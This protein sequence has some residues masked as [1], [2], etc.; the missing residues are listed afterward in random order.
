M[1][2][3]VD[4]S[5]DEWKNNPR[6][7]YYDNLYHIGSALTPGL[8]MKDAANGVRKALYL[9]TP[10]GRQTAMA[11]AQKNAKNLSAG[12]IK[13][14]KGNIDVK[15]HEAFEAAGGAYKTQ[16]L[17]TGLALADSN[18][19][20]WA[21][22]PAAGNDVQTMARRISGVIRR[23]RGGIG[24]RNSIDRGVVNTY[25][26]SA[27]QM[28]E[29]GST[30]LT[31]LQRKLVGNIVGAE[32]AK[33]TLRQASD[34][35]VISPET[36]INAVLEHINRLGAVTG[37]G[38]ETAARNSSGFD[39]VQGARRTDVDLRKAS[40]QAAKRIPSVV[41]A[42]ADQINSVPTLSKITGK[43]AEQLQSI[44]DS[45]AADYDPQ[46]H[47]YYEPDTTELSGED[48]LNHVIHHGIPG[49]DRGLDTGLLGLYNKHLQGG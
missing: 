2:P 29:S 27:R 13:D 43:P 7:Q 36:N 30:D 18:M 11:N 26:A 48:Y 10:Q 31:D 40:V 21:T 20:S 38:K 42:M 15:A 22:G 32:E 4:V 35:T 37:G 24:K 14:K 16:R 12:V 3:H 9:L 25:V 34:I 17:Q 28:V 49:A 47:G 5:E 8:S 45:A 46:T 33:S 23:A 1:D 41:M 39:P 6:F 19:A 44:A